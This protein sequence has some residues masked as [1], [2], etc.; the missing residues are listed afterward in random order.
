MIIVLCSNQFAKFS[1]QNKD[2]D[3]QKQALN[4]QKGVYDLHSLK[5][6]ADNGNG[7]S[8]SIDV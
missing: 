1:K 6:I 7:H 3:I 8:C 4:P 2:G 5:L